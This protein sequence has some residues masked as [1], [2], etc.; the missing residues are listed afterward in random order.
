MLRGFIK[1]F[2][3]FTGLALLFPRAAA[4]Y[5]DP[6]AGSMILQGLA[7]SAIGVLVF[8]RDLR[9]RIKDF[10]IGRAGRAEQEQAASA[11]PHLDER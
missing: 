6:G 3:A 5:I 9:S 10:F 2:I 4:A 1:T 8:W 7:A 11:P